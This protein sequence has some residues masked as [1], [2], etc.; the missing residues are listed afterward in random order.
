MTDDKLIRLLK[1]GAWGGAGDEEMALAADRIEALVKDLDK[2]EDRERVADHMA[3]KYLARAEQ[4]EAA[5][6]LTIRAD[7]LRDVY[8]AMPNDNHR[9]GQ[10]RSPKAHARD[11]WLRAFRKAAIACRTAL[12]GADHV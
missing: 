7:D 6:T 12:K 11:A 3:A 8:H 10:K 9:I 2:A 1:L 4:M 5:L